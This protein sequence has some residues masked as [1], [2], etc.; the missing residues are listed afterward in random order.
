M[1]KIQQLCKVLKEQTVK[2][3]ITWKKTKQEGV[4]TVSL[5]GYDIVV[6][7]LDTKPPV[8]FLQIRCANQLIDEY[9]LHSV[10]F[11][12]FYREIRRQVN[13]AGDVIDTLLSDL[14]A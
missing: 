14:A 13:H 8:Y 10:E 6:K 3:Q 4:Y 1:D 11:D 7:P 2:E 9:R 5:K 12:E